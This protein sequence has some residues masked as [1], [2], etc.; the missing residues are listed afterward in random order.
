MYPSNLDQS[1][2]LA[3]RFCVAVDDLISGTYEAPGLLLINPITGKLV[4]SV[5]DQRTSSVMIGESKGQT[6]DRVL[7]L[8][9]PPTKVNACWPT[10]QQHRSFTFSSN[11]DAKC[12]YYR[13]AIDRAFL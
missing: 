12:R 4:V 3:D 9:T 7:G 2:R 5:Q 8:C 6:F 11:R 1:K 13:L 10:I